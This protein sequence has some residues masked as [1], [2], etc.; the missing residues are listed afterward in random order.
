MDVIEVLAPST[1]PA[2]A[3]AGLATIRP[4]VD[5]I[6]D[7]RGHDPRSPYVERYWLGV[8]GPT[9][10]MIM[11]RFAQ[12]FDAAPDGFTTDLGHLAAAM[13]LSFRKGPASPFGR[14]LHRCVM[15]GL[16]QPMAGGYLVRRRVPTVSQR[17]LQRLPADL[18]AEHEAWARGGT[19]RD[20]A[21]RP[22]GTT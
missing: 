11:R 9:A 6:V 15:F 7:Q 8:I 20:P 22:G 16:A 3:P 1:A 12:S 10:T 5:P 2:P 4:W 21:S 18:R 14:A 17:H 19:A 13:G